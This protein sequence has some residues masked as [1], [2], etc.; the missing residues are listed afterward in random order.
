MTGHLIY[1]IEPMHFY[2]SRRCISGVP[3]DR[4]R[5]NGIP[6]QTHTTIGQ[7]ELCMQG[8]RKVEMESALPR[9]LV[10]HHG[11]REHAIPLSHL[12]LT[13]PRGYA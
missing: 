10:S 12:G 2:S 6:F 1:M 4:R 11:I 7:Q 5:V 13:L 8:C 9:P 3:Y